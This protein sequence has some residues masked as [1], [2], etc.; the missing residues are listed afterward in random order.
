MRKQVKNKRQYP[1]SAIGLIAVKSNNADVFGTAFLI[2]SNLALTYAHNCYDEKER[3]EYKKPM[4]FPALNGFRG[5]LCKVKKIYYPEEYTQAK[6]EDEQEK[7]DIALLE[8]EDNFE[9]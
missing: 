4:F 1:F 9:D 8:L 6:S 2:G 7:F 3:R 5:D